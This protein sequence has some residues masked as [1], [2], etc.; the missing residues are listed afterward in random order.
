MKGKTQKIKK[1]EK[2]KC[3][4]CLRC[5]YIRGRACF[6]VCLNDRLQGIEIANPKGI[7]CNYFIEDENSVVSC[8]DCEME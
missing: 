8:K 6:Y 4:C 3:K 1:Q 2:I 7:V 5:K